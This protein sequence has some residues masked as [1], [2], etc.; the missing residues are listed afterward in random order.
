MPSLSLRGLSEQAYEGLRQLAISNHRSMQ[1]QV[2]LLIEREVRYAQVGG[3]ERARHWRSLLAVRHV[4]NL[5]ADI[6]ADRSR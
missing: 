6:Q 4:P 1:E 2:R 3:V 5:A